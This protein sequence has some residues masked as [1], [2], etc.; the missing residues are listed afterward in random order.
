MRKI[1]EKMLYAILQKQ[2]KTM[3]NTSVVT[4]RDN[5]LGV[6]ADVYLH[7]NLIASIYWNSMIL[8]ASNCGWQTPT[9][10]SRLNSILGK[11]C[12]IGI[13]QRKGQWFFANWDSVAGWGQWRPWVNKAF[14]PMSLSNCNYL[15]KGS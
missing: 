1:E 9:T 14:Y 12:N 5:D 2:C 15:T 11:F 4:T 10:K 3:S 7:G 6:V 8:E 13:A